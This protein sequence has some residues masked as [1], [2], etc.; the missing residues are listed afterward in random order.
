MDMSKRQKRENPV[1]A[2]SAA[3]F[4]KLRALVGEATVG[5]RE[6]ER[7]VMG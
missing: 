6:T 1:G 4:G 3:F 2:G 5:I 7:V